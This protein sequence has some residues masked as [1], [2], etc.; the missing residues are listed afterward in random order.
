MT[1]QQHA[2]QTP[3]Q[4]PVRDKIKSIDELATITAGLRQAGTTLVH[5]HGVFDLLHIGHIRYFEQA[6]RLG[7]ILLV[8]LTPDR[9]VDKGPQRPAFPEQL[10]A[11]A[12]ASLAG[13]DYIAINEW[14]TAEETLR[15][16]RPHFYVKGSEFKGISDDRT[17][18]IGKEKEVADE[19]GITVAFADDIVFSSSNLINRYLS[20]FSE[21][22]DSYLQLLRRRYSL[23]DVLTVLDRMADLKILVMGDTI[24]DEYQ[25]CEAI[26][27]SSKDPTLA[28]RYQSSD[29]FAGGVLAVANHVAHFVR[30][31]DLITVIG[32][33]DSQELFIRRHLRHNIAPTFLVQPQSPTTVK[34]RFVDGY[35]FNKLLEIYVMDDSGLDETQT[36]ALHELLDDRLTGYDLVIAADFGHGAI[37][38][39]TRELLAGKAPFLAVNTQ[40]NAGNRGFHTISKY[41]RAHYACIARHELGCLLRG[42]RHGRGPGSRYRTAGTHRQRGRFP[43]GGDHRQQKGHRPPEHGKIPHRPDEVMASRYPLFDRS[44]LRCLPLAERTHDLDLRCLLP[45]APVAEPAPVFREIGARILTARGQGAAVVLLMGAHVLRAGVQR[46]LIDLLERGL[47]SCIAVNGAA[48]I[49]DYELALVGATTESVARYIAEGQFGLWQETGRLN[50]IVR[51]AAER[52]EGIGEAVGRHIAVTAPPHADISLLAAAWRCGV[53]LTVHV[54]IGYD[55]VHEHPSCDGGAWGAASYTDFLIFARCLASLTGGVVMNFGSAVMAPEVFLK[56]LAMARNVAQQEGRHIEGFSTLVCDLRELPADYRREAPRD[57][58]AYYFRPWKTMLV[59]TLRD[60]ASHYV[61][62]HHRETVPALWTAVA[63]NRKQ[64]KQ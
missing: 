48:V 15:R 42:Q 52:G 21:E 28:L 22:V 3:R 11:E 47:L 59:R 17:G 29:L 58:P 34:R 23:D 39:A 16:L 40:A 61:R 60:G 24:I 32:G 35:S 9:F 10:R 26:G 64:E 46:Y 57:D 5:C 45:L 31:L 25:Y 53:P 38:P 56:A 1:E 41:P 33:I 36:Q 7:D 18:K 37:N 62:G 49:H 13:V 43:G 20:T 55:I 19:L 12:I 30:T 2:Q 54:G 51:E 8:T 6:R 50:D 63:E 44:R 4:L 14:P 27:K